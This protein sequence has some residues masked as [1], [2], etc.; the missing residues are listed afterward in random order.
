MDGKENKEGQ[1]AWFKALD[2]QQFLI[3]E[4]KFLSPFMSVLFFII[5]K[6]F[7]CSCVGGKEWIEVKTS[8]KAFYEHI[9]LKL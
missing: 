2:L 7:Y 6:S 8:R 4:Q 3:L 5:I 9:L 1:M